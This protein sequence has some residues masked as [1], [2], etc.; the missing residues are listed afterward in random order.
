MGVQK[1]KAF[2]VRHLKGDQVVLDAAELQS[3]QAVTP[4]HFDLIKQARCLWRIRS[5]GFMEVAIV[6]PQKRCLCISLTA[7]G[8]CVQ[9]VTIQRRQGNARRRTPSVKGHINIDPV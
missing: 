8:V 2:E 7:Q 1:I 4:R 6:K 9:I 3:A 5:L